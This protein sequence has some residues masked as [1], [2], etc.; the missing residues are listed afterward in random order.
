MEEKVCNK[1]GE[2]K[3]IDLFILRTDTNGR[4]RRGT[5]EPCRAAHRKTQ[6]EANKSY[7]NSK[8]RENYQK[9]KDHVLEK[10]RQWRKSNPERRRELAKN[11]YEKNEDK[12]KLSSRRRHLKNRYGIT[13]EEYE[14]LL[15]SQ[16]GL[17]AN[18]GCGN[19]ATDVDHCHKIGEMRGLL[20]NGCNIS[21]GRLEEDVHRIQGLVDYILKWS[22]HPLSQGD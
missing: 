3:P 20:C 11:W 14:K 21:L 6:Y 12:A 13:P 16:E 22:P 4:C 5:C 15:K 17:C 18:L 9:D 10:H 1:C 2:S 8:S 7:Y 19:L